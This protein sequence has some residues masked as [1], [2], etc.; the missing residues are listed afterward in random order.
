MLIFSSLRVA[1]TFSFCL[2]ASII[3]EQS[4]HLFF[5]GP[6][7][8]HLS[9]FIQLCHRLF[10]SYH[11]V[12]TARPVS[13]FLL[14]R[15]IRQHLSHS[16]FR[17]CQQHY[18]NHCLDQHLLVQMFRLIFDCHQIL[19]YTINF[20]S[21]FYYLKVVH[22]PTLSCSSQVH[23]ASLMNLPY[24]LHLNASSFILAFNHG[25]MGH[26]TLDPSQSCPEVILVNHASDPFLDMGAYVRH[27]FPDGSSAAWQGR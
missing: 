19:H 24:R 8:C 10:I 5:S 4:F 27:P 13:L 11:H 20:L 3:H 1:I 7:L 26:L 17:H 22:L 15:K 9:F 23:L 2:P 21:P 18:L 6:L 14:L 12:L 16:G 25:L